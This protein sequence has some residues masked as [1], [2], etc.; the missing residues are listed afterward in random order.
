[1]GG[2]R[3]AIH[4]PI[5]PSLLSY[6]CCRFTNENWIYSLVHSSHLGRQS[7]VSIDVI[8][9][10]V[11]FIYG[12]LS[13]GWFASRQSRDARSYI[14]MYILYAHTKYI[15]DLLRSRLQHRDYFDLWFPS[16]VEHIDVTMRNLGEI[17]PLIATFPELHYN[18]Y[19]EIS[20]IQTQHTCVSQTV[21]RNS[22]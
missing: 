13:G 20:R 15:P 14:L 19:G 12:R 21:V 6:S 16:S 22:L 7:I 11:A 9:K 2:G 4:C 1:M 18:T 10:W 17:A 8:I 5:T 3:L